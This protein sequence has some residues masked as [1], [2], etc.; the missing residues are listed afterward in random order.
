MK[1]GIFRLRGLRSKNWKRENSSGS[2]KP[3][4]RGLAGLFR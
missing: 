1:S 4:Q 3:L 2:Q